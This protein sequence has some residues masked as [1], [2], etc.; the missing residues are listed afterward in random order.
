[1]RICVCIGAAILSAAFLEPG[2]AATP[3][4]TA[5]AVVQA[6]HISGAGGDKI[7]AP[8]APVYSGDR[9]S[10]DAVGTAQIRFRDDTKLVVGPNSSLVIDAFVFSGNT[11]SNISLNAVKGAFRFL[12]GKSPKNAYKITTPTAT[13][14][15]RGTKF[16]I[17]IEREGTTRVADY[18]GITEICR[19]ATNGAVPNPGRCVQS[20]QPCTLT[21]VRPSQSRAVRYSNQDVGFRNRQLKYYFPYVRSQSGLL[22]DFQVDLTDCHLSDNLILPQQSPQ[23]PAP[24]GT[25][26]APQP[27]PTP[28]PPTP[29]SVTPPSPPSPENRHES[30]PSYSR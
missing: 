6:A 15:V 14:G 18:E 21:V 10:T 7:L 25:P 5:I 29:P 20:N 13:I 4:G 26:P 12:T 30:R 8:E 19:G 22:K 17:S 2:M 24:P 16:D 23:Q 28:A 11:G 1:M 3:S 27:P 9:I